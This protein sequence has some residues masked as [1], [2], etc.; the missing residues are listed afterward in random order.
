MLR[1]E[2]RYPNSI[3]PRADDRATLVSPAADAYHVAY[4][5]AMGSAADPS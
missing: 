5:P 3:R 1:F 4:L 2:E